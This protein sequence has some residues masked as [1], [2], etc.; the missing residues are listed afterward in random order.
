MCNLIGRDRAAALTSAR[1]K[2]VLLFH[3]MPLMLAGPILLLAFSP[4]AF[5]STLVVGTCSTAGFPTIQSAVNTASAGSTILICPGT[6]PEQVLIKKNLTLTGIASNG[7]TGTSATGAN[8]PVIASPSGGIVSNA[9][10]LSDGSSIGAQVAVLAPSGTSITVNLNF[11]AVDGANNQI[12]GC[13]PPD[14]LVGIYYQNASGTINQVVA[15]NQALSAADDGCQ[16]GLAIFAQSGYSSGGTSTVTIENSSVHNYQKNGITADGSGT[17]ATISGN[18]IVGQGPTTGAAENGIQVSDGANGTV[19]DNTVTDDIYI[20]PPG[21]LPSCYG[22]SGI[23]IY[24][25]GATSTSLLTITGNTVSNTQL[26][27]VAYGDSAGTADYNTVTSN[28]VTG[29]QASGPYLDDGIDLCS[30]NNTA[31]SNTV[32]NSSASGIHIDSTCTESTG[33]TGN[34]TTVTKN[35]IN[36]ACAGTLTGSGT[37]SSQSNNTTYNV[38]AVTQTGDSCPAGA[39]GALT[40]AKARLKPNPRRP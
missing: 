38:V 24:D 16:S 22:A 10:D 37:G 17:V 11:I 27:I 35:T 28:K 4:Q 34:N 23:I 13:S 15:R 36:E 31:T 40:R 6:Y 19:K 33:G 18:Y 9:S 3:R 25:S 20:N 29:T 39:P 5:S 1:R 8:N 2:S 32:F 21:C 7:S 12:S 26:A 14:D 30:N